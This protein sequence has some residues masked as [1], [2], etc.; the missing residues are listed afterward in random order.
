[1]ALTATIAKELDDVFEKHGIKPEQCIQMLKA[2][3]LT[4][5]KKGD[6]D[7]AK[8]QANTYGEQIVCRAK[9]FTWNK[10]KVHGYDGWN[11]KQPIEIKTTWTPSKQANITYKLSPPLEGET[12]TAY[13]RRMSE[14]YAKVEHHWAIIN[15]KAEIVRY[16]AIP[17]DAF[18]RALHRYLLANP[19]GPKSH[20]LNFG[21][22]W[23]RTCKRPKMAHRM[24]EMAR[25]LQSKK[26]G[27]HRFPTHVTNYCGGGAVT[28]EL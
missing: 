28:V 24:D 5:A 8:L 18:G 14:H 6:I 27:D 20:K 1:M 23:C 17:G 4:L 10:D 22:Q 12:A 9:G 2:Y 7:I 26:S 15:K 25:L 21:C 11:G 19:H 13:A 3:E 16:Y